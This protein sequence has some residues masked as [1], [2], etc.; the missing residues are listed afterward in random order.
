GELGTALSDLNQGLQLAPPSVEL[1]V[2]RCAV[3]AALGNDAAATQDCAAALAV[4][5][6]NG[7]ALEQRGLLRQRAGDRLGAEADFR[8]AVRYDPGAYQ[9]NYY[10]GL[11]ALQER[12]PAEAI[13]PLTAAIDAFPGY[14][15]AYA[16]RG[17]A[18]RLTEQWQQALADLEQ[19]VVLVPEDRYNYYELGLVLQ[20]LADL[21]YEGGNIERA[22][23]LYEDAGEAYTTYLNSSPPSSDALTQA[24]IGLEYVQ[25]ALTVIRASN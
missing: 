25:Q 7:L 13:P 19:A 14:G 24:Q 12:R 18:Y 5:P 16:A 15:L 6:F 23:T 11:F 17:V 4:E 9:A 22:E 10:L 20:N 8:E 21:A 3:H 2:A 1:R